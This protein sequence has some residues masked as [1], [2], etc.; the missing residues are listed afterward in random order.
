MR[1]VMSRYVPGSQ[2]LCFDDDWITSANSNPKVL[3]SLYFYQNDKE[4]TRKSWIC[5]QSQRQMLKGSP[6]VDK[7]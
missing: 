6:L 1:A 5:Y 4:L 7:E 3:I 2:L